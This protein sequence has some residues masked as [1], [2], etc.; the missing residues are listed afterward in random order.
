[1]I[2]SSDENPHASF[3]ILYKEL[4]EFSKALT[5]KPYIIVLSK[6]DLIDQSNQEKKFN[7][8]QVVIPVSSVTGENLQKVID[9]FYELVRKVK[10][11]E[12][13]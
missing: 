2:D 3:K 13:E 10:D 12:K 8:K 11:S 9:H 6:S 1:M 5:Q 7:K 4:G